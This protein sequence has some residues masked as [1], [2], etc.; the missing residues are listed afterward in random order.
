[1]AS[2]QPQI[3]L[4]TNDKEDNK[5]SLKIILTIIVI[6]WVILGIT[7]F[8]MSIVCFG[9]SG[10]SSQHVIG[11]LLSIFF[12]PIYWIFYLAVPD[13]CKRLFS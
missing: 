6:F 3:N 1:M 4:Y 8:I 11:L 12:G 7:G 13:Y 9:R 10:T 2:E 5:S